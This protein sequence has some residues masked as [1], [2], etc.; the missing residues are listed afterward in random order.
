MF[1]KHAPKNQ[2]NRV[3]KHFFHN[4]IFLSKTSATKNKAITKK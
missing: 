4:M 2:Y 1:R 3:A